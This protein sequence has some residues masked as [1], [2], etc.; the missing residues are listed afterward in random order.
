MRIGRDEAFDLLG[1][2][3]SERTLLRCDLSFPSTVACF[4]GRLL[5]VSDIEVALLSDDTL[6]EMRLRWEPLFE[7]EYADS[8]GND[9]ADLF[10]GG[11]MVFLRPAVEGEERDFV[12]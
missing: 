12:M 1:K 10:G 2:W 3:F 7:F 8:R 11:L 4:R 5:R 6:T 9:D